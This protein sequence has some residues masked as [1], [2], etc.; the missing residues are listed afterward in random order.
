MSGLVYK[1]QKPYNQ[2]D[3]LKGAANQII[4]YLLQTNQ[5]IFKLLKYIEPNVNPYVQDDLTFDEKVSMVSTQPYNTNE[6]TTK[7]ILFI[8]EIRE[9]FSVNIAQL[10]IESDEVVR[11]DPCH[12]Y[13]K[14]WFQIIVP[15]VADVMA[16]TTITGERRTDAICAELIG[17]LDKVI[18][19]DSGFVSEI[20]M[21]RNAPDNSGR[22]NGSYRRKANTDYVERWVCFAVRTGG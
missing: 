18:I 12:G 7:N 13:I 3:V 2:Y 4:N 6:S 16:N 5:T 21:N 22:D 11:T 17:A 9:G 14:I 8:T 1:C 19:D 15:I 20:Y 10:R